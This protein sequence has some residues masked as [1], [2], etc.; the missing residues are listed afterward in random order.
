MRRQALGSRALAIAAAAALTTSPTALLASGFQ[1]VEQNASGLGNAYAGQAAGVQDASAVFFNPAALTRLP[2][3]QFVAAVSE[4]GVSNK[5]TDL[6]SDLPSLG[7]LRIPVPLGGSGG[8]AGGFSPLPNAY[9]SWEA[10]PR[11]WLGL[12]VNAPFGLK[13]EWDD[14]WMGR[15]HA[16]KSEVKTVNINPTVAFRAFDVLSL[17]VGVSYQ[18]VSAELSQS[19][20]YGGISAAAAAAVGGP[21]A[22]AG[23]LAQLGGPAGLAREG[24]GNIEGH[25]WSWGWNA[26]ALLELG[27]P[28]RVG[29]AY[30]SRIE[31]ALEGEAAFAGAPSFLTSG[32]LGALGAS[33]NARFAPGPVT[34]TIELPETVSV[35]AAYQGDRLELLADWT[36]TG[37][38]SIQ[39][40]P[41]VRTDGTPLSDAS[42]SFQDISRVGFGLNY[43]A[44]EH[45][46]LRLGTAFDSAPVQDRYRT[47]RLPDADRTWLAAGVQ[48]KLGK[49]GALDVGYAHLFVNDASSQLPN[50][51]GPTSAPGGDLVGSY[52]SN[53]DIV[54]VQYRLSF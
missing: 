5:F 15:F 28:V 1:L 11:L 18:R 50:Q 48:R 24:V 31:H 32:P 45:W 38:S 37:W 25:D 14:A 19:V 46:T 52:E 33:L 36:W 53:V 23:I 17:G 29:V 44:S 13:T 22:L 2:G 4:V 30:R 41:I 6:G 42:L 21:P 47:P 26:G 39:S 54:S 3:R 8:D 43:L 27:E 9:L 49:N 40:L 35:A 51:D 16:L 7:S 12:G 34:A 20:A 10:T